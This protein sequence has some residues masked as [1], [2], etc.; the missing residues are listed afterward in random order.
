L[1]FDRITGFLK[2][3]RECPETEDVERAIEVQVFLARKIKPPFFH[4]SYP[5]LF[6]L[7]HRTQ[8]NR[9]PASQAAGCS[10]MFCVLGWRIHSIKKR[11]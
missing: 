1:D 5:E 6:A 11:H 8:G 2:I 7:M 9:H 3:F 10:G 4:D